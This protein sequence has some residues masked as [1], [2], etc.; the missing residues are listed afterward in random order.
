MVQIGVGVHQS[1]LTAQGQTKTL[2]AQLLMERVNKLTPILYL[3][4][5]SQS[6]SA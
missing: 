2:V 5:H 6:K 1:M 4:F 3:D